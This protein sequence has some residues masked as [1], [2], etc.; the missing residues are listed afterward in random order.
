MVVEGIPVSPQTIRSIFDS[1]KKTFAA[2][3]Y[4]YPRPS[5]EYLALFSTKPLILTVLKSIFLSFI[6]MTS[7]FFLSSR[8]EIIFSA[9]LAMSEKILIFFKSQ[10]IPISEIGF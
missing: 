4:V 8:K 10:K 1:N 7:S 6:S 9:S 3:S 5:S 2:Y